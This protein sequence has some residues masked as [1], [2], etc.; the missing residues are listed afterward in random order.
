MKAKIYLGNGRH[1]AA[2]ATPVKDAHNKGGLF[3]CRPLDKRF[4]RTFTAHDSSI[5]KWSHDEVRNG[6]LHVSAE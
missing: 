3:E 1:V 5:W 4:K 2:I 6:V